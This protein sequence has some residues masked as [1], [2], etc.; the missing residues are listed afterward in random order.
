MLLASVEEIKTNKEGKAKA[1]SRRCDRHM[2][3]MVRRHI[4]IAIVQKMVLQK[5]E[6]HNINLLLECSH[7]SDYPG[8]CEKLV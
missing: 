1:M 7:G 8:V 6:S 3:D 2:S 4:A 5:V